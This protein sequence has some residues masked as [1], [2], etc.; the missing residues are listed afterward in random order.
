MSTAI[1]K[2][3]QAVKALEKVMNKQY[4]PHFHLAPSAGWMNDPNGLIYFN[5]QYHAFYQHHPYD[6]NWGPMHWGHAVSDDLVT[7]RRLP[8]AIAPDQEFDKSGCFSGSAVDNHGELCLI[9][10]GHLWLAGQGNDEQIRQV[11]CLAS[12]KDGIHFEKQGTV[13]APKN[14]IMHFRDPKVW[15]QDGKWWMVVGQRTPN[16]VG[17][18][19]LYCSDDLKNWIFDHVVVSDIDPDVYMLECPDFFPLGD[20]W[21]LM[22]SPQGMK[23]TGYQ[24]RNRFQSG[25]IVGNWQPGQQFTIIKPFQEMDFGHDFYAPQSFLAADGRRIVFAWMDMW[26]SAMPSKNDKWAGAFTLPRELTL[27]QDNSVRNRPIKELEALREKTESFGE[28]MLSNELKHTNIQSISCELN[29][30]FDL[31][32]SDAER[33]GL[34]L[35]AT[36]DGK[37]ATLL[38]VDLQSDRIILDRSLSGL[39]LSGYRSVPLPKTDKLTLHIFIDASSVEVFVNNDLY[40]L[41]SRIYPQLPAERVINLFAENGKAKVTKLESWQLNS[42]YA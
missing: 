34:Q 5:G 8:I 7:W 17:Q 30:E 36:G 1:D 11:Q 40:S 9:Y 33:F 6:E 38:Y 14:G 13:L 19:L 10:T 42:I 24:Y 12:S 21:I 39:E 27:D 26:E 4:Y 28:I 2:A 18:V 25:Y 3:N 35:A 37:Q 16:D 41:T 31:N 29:V 22:F 32:K 15:Q 23:A 20:K